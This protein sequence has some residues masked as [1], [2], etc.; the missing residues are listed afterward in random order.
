MTAPAGL[1]EE[2]FRTLDSL[3]R[4]GGPIETGRVVDFGAL[5]KEYADVFRLGDAA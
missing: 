5:L 2:W 3:F 1:T 4:E